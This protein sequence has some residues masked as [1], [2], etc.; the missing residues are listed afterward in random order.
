VVSGRGCLPELLLSLSA[1]ISLAIGAR[2][3]HI[4][5]ISRR[6]RPSFGSADD[7]RALVYI[8][9]PG[10]RKRGERQQGPARAKRRGPVAAG[11]ANCAAAGKRFAA[12]ARLQHRQQSTLPEGSNKG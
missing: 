6:E 12:H 3:T 1:V 8:D 2:A 5:S 10:E 9:I 7:K 4:S 11:A